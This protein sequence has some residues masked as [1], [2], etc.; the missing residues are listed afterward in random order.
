[1]ATSNWRC[2]NPPGIDTNGLCNKHFDMVMCNIGPMAA[3]VVTA[4]VGR[5]GGASSRASFG[6]AAAAGGGGGGGGAAAAAA[7]GGGGGAVDGSLNPPTGKFRWHEEDSQ[8]LDMWGDHRRKHHRQGLLQPSS[9]WEVLTRPNSYRRPNRR[10]SIAISNSNN[11]RSRSYGFSSYDWGRRRSTSSSRRR[12]VGARGPSPL[13]EKG[14]K[15]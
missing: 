4:V 14:Q 15:K 3:P 2:K 8:L 10:T 1:M 5:G 9:L 12:L 7:G 13:Q 6:A 11:C